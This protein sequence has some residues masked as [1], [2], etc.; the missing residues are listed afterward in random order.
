[1][2]E[3]EIER[4]SGGPHRIRFED[5][6]RH[7][8][9]P[10]ARKAYFD[11]FLGL[12]GGD[13]FKVRLLIEAGRFTVYHLVAVLDAAQDPARRET[14]ATIGLVKKTMKSMGFVS[15]RQIDDIIGRLCAVGFLEAKPSEHDRRVRILTP[16]ENMHAHDRDWLVA[17][18]APLTVLYPHH[19]YGHVMRRE[20]LF[21]AVH[22]GTCFRFTGL[23]MAMMSM[24][25]PEMMQFFNRAAG[26][27][28]LAA[29][30]Q[31]AMAEA[32]GPHA[33]VPYAEVGDRFGVSRT[34]VRKLLVMAEESGLVK[35][36]ARG[37]HWVEILP[38]TWLLHD[39]GI[40]GGM[41][42]HD[43]VYLAAGKELQ[44]AHPAASHAI[45]A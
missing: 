18:Y 29:L 13:P 45:G 1:M 10:A 35:L 24:V 25:S 41:Y 33:F 43:V 27:P 14:W 23:G 32:D 5:I 34:H 19:D 6:A 28:I 8:H 44:R 7:P 36:H 3:A 2:E 11:R 15:G 26:Y 42:Y 17:H 30:L 20:P 40:S 31:A 12:Y 4:L 37:G 39:L 16:T 22:R 38:R 21:Q 9:F